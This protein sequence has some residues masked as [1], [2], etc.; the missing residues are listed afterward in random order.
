[1]GQT[2]VLEDVISSAVDTVLQGVWTALPG[3]VESF[4][5]PS[6]ANIRAAV[7]SSYIN[8]AG[9]SVTEEVAV[10]TA[11][12]VMQP[13][14]SGFRSYCPLAKGDA[15][16]LVM[17]SRS[18]DQWLAKGGI[19]EPGFT[20]HHH[21]SD[22]VAFTGLR[23]FAHP[24][25]NAPL[26][27]ASIGY[28]EGATIEFRPS[29]IRLGGDDATSK[30]VAEDALDDF[31]TALSNAITTL[32]ATPATPALAALQTA[33]LALHTGTGWKA[34]TSVVKVK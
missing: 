28:D 12:P 32:G 1:M 9:D 27:H 16:M 25:K 29:E 15:V 3:I 33:L 14:G 34:R 31:M 24:L 21:I 11:V 6:R 30:V 8:E 4:E 23:D 18:M 13:G 26:D 19:V 5:N 7:K 22:A 10:F 20:H 17:S 2:F